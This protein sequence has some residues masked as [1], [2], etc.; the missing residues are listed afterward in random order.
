MKKLMRILFVLTI[1]FSTINLN[2]KAGMENEFPTENTFTS[3][4]GEDSIEYILRATSVYLLREMPSLF[5]TIA[6]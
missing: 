6:Q 2:V 5:M 3:N 1:F 4:G